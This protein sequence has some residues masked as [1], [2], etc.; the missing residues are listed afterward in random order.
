M[1]RHFCAKALVAAFAAAALFAAVSPALSVPAWTSPD[2]YRLLLTVDPRGVVRTNSPASVEVDLQQALI[3]LGVSGSLDQ[4]TIEVVAYSAL[5]QPKVFDSSRTGYER[6]LLPWRIVRDYGLTTIAMSFVMPDDTYTSYAIYFDTLDSGLGR[7]DRYRGL[8]GDGDWFSEDYGRREINANL[9]DVFCDFDG[10]GDL[11]LFK[12]NVEPYVYYYENVGANRYVDRGRLTSGGVLMTFPRD[13]SNRSAH[14]VYFCDWDNDGDQDM[15]IYALAGV[16]AF[17]VARYENTT[18]PGGPLTF[19][20]PVRLRTQSAQSLDGTITVVDWDGDGKKDVLSGTRFYKNI[21]T[22]SSPVLADGVQ[23]QA[24]GVPIEF[25]GGRFECADIDN[26]GDLDLFSGSVDGKIYWWTNVGTRTNPVFTIGRMIAFYQYMDLCSGVKVA[27]FDGDGLLD[28]VA[29]RLW[30]RIQWGEQPR[31]YGCV[32]KN[33]GTP[34]APVFEARDAYNGSPY[35]LRFQRCDSGKQN[36]V[37]AVDWDND[38]KTDLL[39]SDTD[40][41]VSFHRNLT[42]QLFPIFA[43]GQK[44]LAG[45][46]PLRVWGELREGRWAGYARCDVCDWNNDGKKDLLVAD[47]RGY[48][49]LHLNEGT[50]AD[51]VLAAGTRISAYNQAGTQLLPIDGTARASVLVCDWNNDGKKDVIFAMGGEGELSADYSWPHVNADPGFDRGFLFYENVGTDAGPVLAYP[52]WITDE[53]GNLITYN[54]RPNL[55]SYVDWNGDGKKDFITGE[56]ENSIPYYQNI[57]SGTGEPVFDNTTGVGLVAPFT[58]QMISGADAKDFNADGDLD[59]V[60]GQGHSGSGL[61]FYERDYINDFVNNTYPTVTAGSP[62]Q[63]ITI[64][65]AKSLPDGSQANLPQGIVSAAFSDFFYIESLDRVSGIRVEKAAHGLS[66][67]DRVAVS[68]SIL[69]NADGERYIAADS[70]V[71]TGSAAWSSLRSPSLLWAART[72]PTILRPEPASKG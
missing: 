18:P 15:F 20:D 24:N 58:A 12:A 67:G 57:G 25:W 66:V 47:G 59:I 45:G 4:D 39:A 23:V 63:G 35:T 34:T 29:G 5:G 46:V 36:G 11:D 16:N 52:K 32:Y 54:S 61:R 38:G 19:A 26:D 64:A 22:D 28:F 48:L 27:D 71:A 40:G 68:G 17:D 43:P 53:H 13:G 51:P 44:L 7:P 10:D 9:C 60:T 3:S 37:R 8:V 42:N 50:D 70:A 33:V 55:G 1:K 6:Y 30:E 72:G 41:F 14:S 2:R 21:G 62:Q 69:T 31:F 56:F 65:Q 49:W